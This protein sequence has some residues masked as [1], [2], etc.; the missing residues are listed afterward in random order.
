MLD[1]KRSRAR[2]DYAKS[3]VHTIHNAWNMLFI[4]E[5]RYQFVTMNQLAHVPHTVAHKVGGLKNAYVTINM[6]K[7]CHYDAH[8][9]SL[10]HFFMTHLD[11]FLK[12]NTMIWN[13]ENPST[14]SV[15]TKWHRHVVFLWTFKFCTATVKMNISTYCV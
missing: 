5:Q 12:M 11:H 4:L 1:H 7:N 3:V 6:I 10:A 8:M 14:Y 9:A 13:H 2:F 15:W